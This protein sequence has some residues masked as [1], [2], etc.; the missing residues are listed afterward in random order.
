MWVAVGVVLRSPRPSTASWSPANADVPMIGRA[1]ARTRAEK[2]GVGVTGPRRR[3]GAPRASAGQPRRPRGR[4]I[5]ATFRGLYRG[6]AATS[7]FDFWSS[8]GVP[9]RRRGPRLPSAVHTRRLRGERMAHGPPLAPAEVGEDRKLNLPNDRVKGR[10]RGSDTG[11]AAQA[12]GIQR[13]RSRDRGR[14]SST[15]RRCGVP[16]QPSAA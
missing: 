6:V 7:A 1:R 16:V 4:G 10:S 2:D 3:R 9:R 15:R 8:L 11:F 5:P 12:A 14:E 13:C